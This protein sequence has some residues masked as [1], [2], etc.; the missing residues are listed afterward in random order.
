M[1]RTCA[2]RT[3]IHYALWAFY[4]AIDRPDPIRIH[5][6]RCSQSRDTFLQVFADADCLAVTAK[7]SISSAS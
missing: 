7:I 5:Y 4:R 1:F 6:T 3:A 2:P